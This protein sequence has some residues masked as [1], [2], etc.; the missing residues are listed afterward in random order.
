MSDR[1]HNVFSYG[2][3]SQPEADGIY[4]P[5]TDRILIKTD[6]KFPALFLFYLSVQ[7]AQSHYTSKY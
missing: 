1:T 2:M 3:A 4:Q 7:E 6:W 5:N